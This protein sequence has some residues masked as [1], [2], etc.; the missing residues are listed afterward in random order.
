MTTQA[1][2]FDAT[3]DLPPLMKRDPVL[4][5]REW[6]NLNPAAWDMIVRWSLEDHANGRRCSIGFYAELLRRPQYHL[7]RGSSPYKLDQNIRAVLV[8]MLIDE[9]PNLADAFELRSSKYDPRRGDAHT[10]A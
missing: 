8:R 2:I 6:R 5:A 7:R 9:Y 1:S 4:A 10:V 3:D